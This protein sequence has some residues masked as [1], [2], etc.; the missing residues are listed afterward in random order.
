MSSLK[1]CFRLLLTLRCVLVPDVLFEFMPEIFGDRKLFVISTSSRVESPIFKPD[2]SSS[3]YVIK[4]I[5]PR[6]S[7]MSPFRT[8]T[9]PTR[10]FLRWSG[11]DIVEV[12][13]SL[14]VMTALRFICILFFLSA[15]LL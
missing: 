11:W 8:E 14:L 13:T 15:I 2:F 7:T 3:S 9:G 5:K 10:G 1:L 6:L 12:S 4:G